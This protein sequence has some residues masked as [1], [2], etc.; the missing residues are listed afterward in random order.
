MSKILSGNRKMPARPGLLAFFLPAPIDSLAGRF[1]RRA[2]SLFIVFAALLTLV[3]VGE[4]LWLARNNLQKELTIYQRT[5]EKS[6]A[7]ALWAMDQE[8]LDSIVRGIIEI[9]DIKGVRITDPLSGKL[10]IESGIFLDEASGNHLNLIHRFAVIHDEGFGQERVATAEFHS[11]VGQIFQRTQGQI[12]L[13]VILALLKTIAFWIIFMWVGRRLLGDPLTEM[14]AAIAAE[15]TP[16]RLELSP[17]TEAAIDGTELAELRQAHDTLADQIANVQAEL[18]CINAELEERVADRTAALNVK[19]QEAEQL[20]QAKTR[21]LAAASHDLRQPLYAMLL[22]SDDLGQSALAPSQKNTLDQLRRLIQAMTTQLQQLLE[23]SRLDMLEAKPQ[24]A[25]LSVADLFM[26]LADI[27]AP[28]AKHRG[29]RLLFHPGPWF[30]HSDMQL[31]MRLLGNLIDN[32]LKFAQGGCV[33]V[34]ARRRSKGILIQVRDNGPGIPATDQPAVFQEFYQVR[35]ENRNPDAGLGLGL[36]IVQRIARSLGA[37]VTLRTTEGKGA[38][39]SILLPTGNPS[40]Q[41]LDAQW[42]MDDSGL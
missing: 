30:I 16:H 10:L 18:L 2:F 12:A 38:V 34:C 13:I 26:D 32:A 39:F 41:P 27:H 17:A 40:P 29:T 35:N 21:F 1:F 6:L 36:A 37:R 28:K 5:F 31:T 14:T 42:E 20:A 23:L 25:D 22:F 24:I 4:T 9:P 11:S 3:L 15:S 7:A 8:K 19:R 33:L